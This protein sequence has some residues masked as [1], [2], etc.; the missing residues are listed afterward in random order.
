VRLSGEWEVQE[1][2]YQVMFRFM[3]EHACAAERGD[4]L[5]AVASHNCDRGELPSHSPPFMTVIQV[6]NLQI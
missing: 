1:A 6:E 5:F 2:F 3:Y 4:P